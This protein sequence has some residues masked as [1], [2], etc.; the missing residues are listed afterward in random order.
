METTSAEEGSLIWKWRSSEHG[1]VQVARD[2]VGVKAVEVA[3]GKARTL[4]IAMATLFA[5]LS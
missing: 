3:N 2:F 1:H 4:G 5:G